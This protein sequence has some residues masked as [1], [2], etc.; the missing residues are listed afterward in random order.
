MDTARV[1]MVA[2]WVH[3]T[4][5]VTGIGKRR[6]KSLLER[7]SPL[8]MQYFLIQMALL[9]NMH[10]RLAKN[11]TFLHGDIPLVVWARM[12]AALGSNVKEGTPVFWFLKNHVLSPP[13]LNKTALEA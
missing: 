8:S 12:L 6:V 11:T 2:L 10:V 7:D 1:N 5:S 4:L 13:S 9:R 3:K